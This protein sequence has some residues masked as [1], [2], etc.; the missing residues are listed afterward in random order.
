MAMFIGPKHSG[1]TVAACSFIEPDKMVKV[2]DFDGRIRGLL[3]A[4]WIDRSKIDYEYYPPKTPDK[5]TMERVNNDFEVLQIQCQD[6][7]SPYGTVILDSLTSQTSALIADAIPLTH[8]NRKG[9]NIG[10]VAMAGPEDYGYE[11]TGTD[12]IMR[13]LRSLP[14]KNVILTA[15]IV[16]RIGKLVPDDDFSERGVIGEKLS[17]RDKIGTN[18]MIYFDH[19]FRFDRKMVGG[20]ERFFVKFISDI[21]CTSFENMPTGEI[22]ITG[23]PFNSLMLELANK[24]MSNPR[25]GC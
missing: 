20:R 17:V 24:G 10:T 4:P 21:A 19:I 8:A 22:D 18:T 15:H 2:F 1:K 25:R 11:S 6:G 5:T 3:G 14:I 13:F 12:Q 7:K 16:D 9:K 23:K